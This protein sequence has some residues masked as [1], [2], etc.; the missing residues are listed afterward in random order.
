MYSKK[1][2]YSPCS[3]SI[4]CV[5]YL[6]LTKIYSYFKVTIWQTFVILCFSSTD[7]DY[8]RMAVFSIYPPIFA[9]KNIKPTKLS[10][11][12]ILFSYTWVDSLVSERQSFTDAKCLHPDLWPI[13]FNYWYCQSFAVMVSWMRFSL[14]L[15]LHF[16]FAFS[17]MQGH[18]I[19]IKSSK[20]EPKSFYFR[21][22][23]SQVVFDIKPHS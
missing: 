12:N 6:C 11:P 1:L 23:S 2:V 9:Q 8:P 3:V 17:G 20:G 7:D 21:C 16:Y 19:L 14:T 5:F 18:W 22:S 10:N 4:S 15:S 13:S